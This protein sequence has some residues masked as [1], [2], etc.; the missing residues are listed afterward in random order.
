MQKSRKELENDDS[1]STTTGLHSRGLRT[2]CG[3][4]TFYSVHGINAKFNKSMS[5]I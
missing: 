4:T 1:S 3:S 2:E 5:R